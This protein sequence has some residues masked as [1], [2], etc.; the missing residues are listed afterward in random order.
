MTKAEAEEIFIHCSSIVDVLGGDVRAMC[1]R[2]GMPEGYIDHFI[3]EADNS[4]YDKFIKAHHLDGSL[5]LS[6]SDAVKKLNHLG[7]KA[8]ITRSKK[9]VIIVPDDRDCFTTV[10]T[11]LCRHL[12]KQFGYSYVKTK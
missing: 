3:K 4:L 9:K 11:N 8:G 7:I 5:S 2:K 1:R 10:E 12:K 6:E